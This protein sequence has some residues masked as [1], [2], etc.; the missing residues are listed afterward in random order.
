MF[1]VGCSYIDIGALTHP[2]SIFLCSFEVGGHTGALRTAWSVKLLLPHAETLLFAL[3]AGK[4]SG[5]S[6]PLLPHRWVP[7]SVCHWEQA[8]ARS[9]QVFFLSLSS[10]SLMGDSL[11]CSIFFNCLCNIKW[12]CC[13]SDKVNNLHYCTICVFL[14]V[15]K[16]CCGQAST[17]CW[18]TSTWIATPQLASWWTMSILFPWRRKPWASLCFLM[19][20]RNTACLALAWAHPWDPECTSPPLALSVGHGFAVTAV[21]IKGWKRVSSI[22]QNS[23]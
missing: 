5:C 18:S 17:T 14:F 11:V 19:R 20:P 9:H 22:A 16:V 7:A 21:T 13:L 12:F 1:T 8:H 10:R 15:L 3:C 4:S 6:R 2:V 23:P